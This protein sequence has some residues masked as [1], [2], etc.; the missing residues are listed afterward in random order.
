[1]SK[2]YDII[3]FGF[4]GFT[5]KLA[6]EHLLVK[7]Y[8]VKWAVCAR[9][10]DKAKALLAEIGKA[11]KASTLPPVEVAELVCVTDEDE[12]KL[13][14]L[15][16]LNWHCEL[17]TPLHPALSP[18]YVAQM[19]KHRTYSQTQPLFDR[20]HVSPDMIVQGPL[21]SCTAVALPERSHVPIDAPTSGVLCS[22]VPPQRSLPYS[23][24]TYSPSSVHTIR[25]YFESRSSSAHP[26][27]AASSCT[28]ISRLSQ[29][30]LS[31]Y[32]SS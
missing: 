21:E 12:A 14:Q 17:D 32:D 10:E 28:T 15:P 30:L 6:A 26:T 4:T 22:G 25:L 3:L 16:A 11:T 20:V 7:G 27:T 8:P 23:W 5:G 2:E 29:L 19:S 31:A 18:W 13:A 24:F 9:N 1:M